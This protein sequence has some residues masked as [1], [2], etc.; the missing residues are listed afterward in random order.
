LSE[1]AKGNLKQTF[2]ASFQRFAQIMPVVQTPSKDTFKNLSLS[3]V[4]GYVLKY[5]KMVLRRLGMKTAA[6]ILMV[7][8][9]QM[10]A[11]GQKRTDPGAP[12]STSAKSMPKSISSEAVAAALKTNSSSSAN[13][14]A[15]IEQQNAKQQ[16][17]QAVQK[18]KPQTAPADLGKNKPMRFSYKPPH[19]P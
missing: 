9:A 7:V 4:E 16:S 3:Q 12:K 17:R 6:V 11:I 15:K 8:L 14:L 5:T 1:A 10:F 19:K 2:L 18:P 13:E